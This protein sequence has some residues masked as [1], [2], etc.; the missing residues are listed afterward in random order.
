[1]LQKN[2]VL[3]GYVS[4]CLGQMLRLMTRFFLLT[5]LML[6]RFLGITA[7]QHRRYTPSQLI[8]VYNN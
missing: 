5:I 2:K 4:Y 8:A 3:S 1:M 7:E 6:L